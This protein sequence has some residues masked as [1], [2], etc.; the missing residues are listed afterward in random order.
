MKPIFWGPLNGRASFKLCL[1][2]L[3][4]AAGR[5]MSGLS[6]D[7][8][9][10]TLAL[11]QLDRLP[12]TRVQP[13][14]TNYL[15]HAPQSEEHAGFGKM[16]EL[17]SSIWALNSAAS[18]LAANAINRS[19]AF[20]LSLTRSTRLHFGRFKA[21]TRS[22]LKRFQALPFA[23]VLSAKA[24]RPTDLRGSKLVFRVWKSAK[25]ALSSSS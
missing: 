8:W 25:P 5:R 1:P 13:I 16:S 2:T 6:A 12:S 23:S 22:L 20:A 24:I 15:P 11:P 9:A 21:S 10:W 17:C 14:G 18:T 7:V 4:K 19:T 3:P